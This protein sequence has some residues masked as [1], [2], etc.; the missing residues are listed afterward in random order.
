MPGDTTPVGEPEAITSYE[1]VEVAVL[2]E[3]EHT[4][5]LTALLTTD[6]PT[7][8]AAL[9]IRRTSE[10]MRTSDM[11]LTMTFIELSAAVLDPQLVRTHPY[12]ELPVCCVQELT[13]GNPM[14]SW[15]GA[16]RLLRRFAKPVAG[17]GGG[18]SGG[19]GGG[20]AASRKA[21]A[22]GSGGEDDR[23]PLGPV[24]LVLIAAEGA[25]AVSAAPVCSSCPLPLPS[26]G[27]LFVRPRMVSGERGRDERSLSCGGEGADQGEG[28][29]ADGA[30]THQ[31]EP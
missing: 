30:L 2:G 1:E 14:S 28:G 16:I 21:A 11:W 22:L 3:P 8:S 4:A 13:A 31:G 29:G 25:P 7:C 6:E 15:A 9:G 12:G 20:G 24:L 19:G 5:R 17:S 23:Y 27:M 10:M 26:S 18:G